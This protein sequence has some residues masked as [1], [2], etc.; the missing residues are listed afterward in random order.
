MNEKK[1]KVT[2][3]EITD[4]SRLKHGDRVVIVENGSKLAEGVL[5][6]QAWASAHVQKET[7]GQIRSTAPKVG[8]SVIERDMI[9]LGSV[10]TGGAS[11]ST[12]SGTKDFKVK[13]ARRETR[14]IRVTIG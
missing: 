7:G 10:L 12:S 8:E 9:T 2:T 6:G 13:G 11:R 3:E 5:Q 4:I 1:P 14:V